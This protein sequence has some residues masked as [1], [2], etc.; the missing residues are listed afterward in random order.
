[1]DNFIEDSIYFF[2]NLDKNI[3]LCYNIFETNFGKEGEK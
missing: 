3:I 1:M 2:E